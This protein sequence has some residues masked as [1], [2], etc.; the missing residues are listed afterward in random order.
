[1][2]IFGSLREGLR[3]RQGFRRAD[4]IRLLKDIILFPK[5][6]AKYRE[7]LWSFVR[8]ELKAKYEGSLLGMFWPVIHPVVLF[9]IYYFIF[10]KLLK[11]PVSVDLMPWADVTAGERLG[12][13]LEDAGSGW[14]ATF[15]LVTGI[16]PWITISESLQRSS[17][18]VIEN[19]NL[20]K[21]IAFP[22][23]FLPTYVVILHTIYFL[24]GFVIFLAIQLLV[25][26][27]LPGTLVWFPLILLLQVVFL[28][29]LG[30]F[31]GALNVFIRDVAQI[32]PLFT[33]FWMFASP[34]FYEPRILAMVGGP[35]QQKFVDTITPYLCV[36]PV[37]NLLTLYRDIFK[38][39]RETE[40][41]QL[42]ADN[43]ENLLMVEKVTQNCG[44]SIDCL[45]IFAAQTV[46]TFLVGYAFFLRSKGRFADE[47]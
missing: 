8:R 18:I 22:S 20:I 30:M 4:M 9:T 17:G 32:V 29:G 41:V 14:R 7:L 27:C 34:V 2:V 38:Y 12:N 24:I 44:I 23:E 1:L 16:L 10:A 37:Y 19:A 6:L 47:V 40:I 25:N 5:L 43:G 15:F 26:G 28:T 31:V 33:I 42:V 45:L 35:K 11:L 46:L 13:V 39:G 21:K 3:R 36:N